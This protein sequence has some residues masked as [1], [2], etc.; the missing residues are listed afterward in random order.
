MKCLIILFY[1]FLNCYVDNIICNDV[2]QMIM[3]CKSENEIISNLTNYYSQNEKSLIDSNNSIKIKEFLIQK[4]YYTSLSFYFYLTN[5]SDF[6]P[7]NNIKE[8]IQISPFFEF[9]QNH[10]HIIIKIKFGKI[11]QFTDENYPK[12][13]FINITKTNLIISSFE[14]RENNIIWYYRN[15]NLFSIAKENTLSTIK[16]TNYQY[17]ILFEKG[18]YTMFWDYLDLITDDHYNIISWIEMAD[19]YE[20][21][22]KFNE[23]RDWVQDK[24]LI[25]DINK[26]NEE[27]YVETK[28]REKKLEKLKKRKKKRDNCSPIIKKEKCRSDNVYDWNY[29]VN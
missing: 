5:S 21:K 7:T 8:I 25:E 27:Q 28:L 23:Y 18:I 9:A 10:S 6:M 3:I 20:K 24:L 17:L 26:Y 11:N 2:Q 1:L 4:K 22:V 29:W 16:E 13:L 14:E 15:L 19:K 12:N